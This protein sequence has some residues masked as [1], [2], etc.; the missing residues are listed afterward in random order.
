M[1]PISI[2]RIGKAL[3]KNKKGGIEG[4][5]LQLMIVIMVA[6]LGTAIIIGWMGNIEEPHSI[7]RVEVDSGDIDLT[8]VN[9]SYTNNSTVRGA[10]NLYQANEDVVI[11][12]YDQSGN[13]LSGA[14]VVLTGLGVNDSK[15]TTPHGT[16]DENGTVVFSDL[17]IRMTGHVG[18]ITVEVSKSG[19]G[20][21]SSCRITVIA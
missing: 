5:P 12:V 13:P 20:E 16:T 2:H 4:L 7:S 21:N 8:G 11:S 17:K 18:Y 1:K 3:R 19:Y 6:T 9:S 14:T 10:N 15:N